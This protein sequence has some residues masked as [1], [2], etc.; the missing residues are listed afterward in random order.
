M[1]TRHDWCVQALLIL[2]SIFQHRLLDVH[3]PCQMCASLGWFYLALA[4]V[5]CLKQTSLGWWCISLYDLNV[6]QPTYTHH[7]WCVQALYD[8]AC[9]CQMSLSKCTQT[10]LDA[11][12]PWMMMLVIN[13]RCLADKRKPWLMSPSRC[14]HA[15]YNSWRIWLMYPAIG[16]CHLDDPR[17]PPLISPSR[18]AH[19]IVDT[20]M[21]WLL[22]PTVSRCRSAN[23]Y[24]QATVFDSCPMSS[25]HEW[26][27]QPMW[28]RHC[29]YVQALG[30]DACC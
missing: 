21:T 14:A 24:A 23:A 29:W 20:C 16:R 28:K 22:L 12:R 30:Y 7:G 3:M 19:S 8:V 25:D 13:R 18:C 5:N 11:R 6:S 26:C 4:N 27:C 9:R 17:S 1:H 2:H 10:T 15:M